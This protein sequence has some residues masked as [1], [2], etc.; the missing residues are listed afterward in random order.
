MRMKEVIEK[1]FKHTVSDYIYAATNASISSIPVVGSFASE[2]L[3]LVISAPIEKRKE[4]WILN[5]AESLEELQEK[6]EGFNLNSLC[7][8]ELFIS[9]LN[10]ASQLAISNH[11]KE[12][13][14]ALKN[15]VINTALNINID[16]NEQMMILNLLDTMTPWHLKLIGYFENP[17]FRYNENNTSLNENIMENP[18]APLI[19]IYIEL[20]GRDGFINLIIQDLYNNGIINNKNFNSV[21]ISSGMLSPRLTDFGMRLLQFIEDPFYKYSV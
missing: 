12:K 3:H 21:M 7:E 4:K 20:E 13:V 1:D 17:T 8:N 6:V 2:T 14:D 19:E 18:I 15:A 16:E 9:I 11:Q 5:I 10:R